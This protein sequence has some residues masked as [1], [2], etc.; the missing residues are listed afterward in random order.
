MLKIKLT[1]LGKKKE[2]RYRIV[3]NEA[4]DK[5][6]GIYVAQV[7]LYQPAQTPKVLNFDVQ[8]YQDW[9]K[10][11]A[12][13]TPTVAFLFE[14]FQSGNPF[15]EKQPKLSK[16]AKAKLAQAKEEK[17]EKMEPTKPAT[18]VE[19]PVETETATTTKAAS[20]ESTP[21]ATTA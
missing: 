2:P 9:L 11:G 12:Q 16:K 19:T 14:R 20:P 10:K 7:G 13:P 6:D 5:R 18:P 4:R 15:P 8:A 21:A 3:V 1:R 17:A